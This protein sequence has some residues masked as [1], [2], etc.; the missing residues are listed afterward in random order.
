MSTITFGKKKT[1]WRETFW[2]PESW[3][4]KL[5]KSRRNLKHEKNTIT[6]FTDYK[7]YK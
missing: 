6:R 3:L 4:P 5:S 7:S 2:S 1:E